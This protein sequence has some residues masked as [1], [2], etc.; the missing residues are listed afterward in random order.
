[1]PPTGLADLKARGI[2]RA[3][4]AASGDIAIGNLL[5]ASAVGRSASRHLAERQTPPLAPSCC[6]MPGIST[7]GDT[8][9]F[10]E[11]NGVHYSHIVD[12]ATGLGLTKRI[13]A[14]IIG[15]DATTTDS[16]DTTV[17]LLGVRRGL[18]LIES[19]PRTAA[20]IVT[21]EDGQTLSFPSRRFGRIPAAL[22]RINGPFPLYPTLS[23]WEREGH[24][25]ARETVTV[26]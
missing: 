4:V 1:M 23:P 10:I 6:T 21:K 2:D 9:Q 19:W 5:P 12:P 17:S 3:L 26:Q 25:G 22:S 18:E 11:I 14:T 13:Q 16:L 24:G 8:E 20:L 15:P 7:S